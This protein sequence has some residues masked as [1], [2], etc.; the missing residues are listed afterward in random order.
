M[1]RNSLNGNVHINITTRA[2]HRGLCPARRDMMVLMERAL[3]NE[4]LLRMG[5]PTSSDGIASQHWLDRL[6][7][8]VDQ[9]RVELATAPDGC[10]S[11]NVAIA[12]SQ[13]TE[14]SHRARYL[15]VHV[16][17]HRLFNKHVLAFSLAKPT[18]LAA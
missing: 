9:L 11:H 12:T 16:R 6:D 17:V 2:Q 10:C 14:V 5:A 3:F 13:R 18:R 4:V 7:A 15:D 1:N 8:F